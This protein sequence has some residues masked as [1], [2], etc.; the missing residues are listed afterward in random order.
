MWVEPEVL[1]LARTF[2]G[3]RI[4]FSSAKLVHPKVDVVVILDDPIGSVIASGT[5][6]LS[7]VRT[8]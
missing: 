8:V 7:S 2:E 4:L 1:E 5:G 6:T 3:S